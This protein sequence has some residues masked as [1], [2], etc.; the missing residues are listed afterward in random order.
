MVNAGAFQLLLV[1]SI[2]TV[3]SKDLM[4]R[5]K[6]LIASCRLISGYLLMVKNSG[7][8]PENVGSI[9]TNRSKSSDKCK[10]VKIAG[11]AQRRLHLPSKQTS[12]WVRVPLPAPLFM[13]EACKICQQKIPTPQLGED[14]WCVHCQKYSIV[15]AE[16][17]TVESE[18]IRVGNFY[19]AYFPMYKSASVAS[20]QDENWQKMRS[21]DMNELTHE[22]AVQ[23]VNKLKTY[24]VFQ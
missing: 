11:M 13:I 12:P 6:N 14:W 4:W 20:T 8:H 18:T 16:D 17:G 5:I 9:P 3:R 1:G 22:Q 19:M 23:W 7:R 15:Y 21:F 10:A 24:V 2:P